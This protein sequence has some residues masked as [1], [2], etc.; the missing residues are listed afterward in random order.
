MC[1]AVVVDGVGDSHGPERSD[2]E[3]AGKIGRMILDDPIGT[4]VLFFE[5][6]EPEK[7]LDE[8]AEFIEKSVNE[9]YTK[10]AIHKRA[11][12]LAKSL[13]AL[14]PH[15]LPKTKMKHRR[16]KYR[17]AECGG[18]RIVNP[19]NEPEVALRCLDCH[20][21]K[22]MENEVGKGGVVTLLVEKGDY[23]EF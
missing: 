14:T 1:G 16:Q 20:N 4:I 5:L 2:D 12:K 21:S 18:K 15:L 10:Q 11:K 3:V 22:S 17:C 7:T 6:M 13:P 19:L 9:T 23:L 8:C